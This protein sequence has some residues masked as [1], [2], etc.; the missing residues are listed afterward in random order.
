MD[1]HVKSLIAVRRTALS[2]TSL[3]SCQGQPM[4][5]ISE[6]AEYQSIIDKIICERNI[7]RMLQDEIKIYK[8]EIKQLKWRLQGENNE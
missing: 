3:M 1:E 4:D 2:G 5:G 6:L 8:L 7:N